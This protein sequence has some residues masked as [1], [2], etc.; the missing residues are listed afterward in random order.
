MVRTGIREAK[1]HET[2]SRI[3]ATALHLFQQNGYE[4]TTLDDIA[5]AA[6]I[7]RRTFF[8]YFRSKDEILLTWH[9]T[10]VLSGALGPS[11]LHESPEQTPLEAARHCLVDLAARYETDESKTVDKIMRSDESL[12]RRKVAV[13]L[14][15][16]E[17]L[18]ESMCALWPEPKR[19][20]ELRATAMIA[21]GALRL[22][23]DDWRD[24]DA[25][26]PLAHYIAANFASI[27]QI[28]Q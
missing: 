22:S 5:A 25:R 17:A 26:H 19:R 16:E 4:A 14:T 13:L 18:F 27:A 23:L 8:Y 6:G 1:R 7:S 24:T 12:R 10:G 21:I 3:A 9:G 20:P 11:M 15:M 28:A 2:F